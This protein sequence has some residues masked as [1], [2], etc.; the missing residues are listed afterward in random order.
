MDIRTR[1]NKVYVNG[2]HIGEYVFNSKERML[3]LTLNFNIIEEKT[4]REL[5]VDNEY[6]KNTSKI[7]DLIVNQLKNKLKKKIKVND[8]M[9][10]N[11]G[12]VLIIW[13]NIDKS[14]KI[15]YNIS[16]FIKFLM[17]YLKK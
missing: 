9:I 11:D 16:N 14:D 12:E 3:T 13:N 15:S 17:K 2:K 1:N 7:T 4:L 8:I 10:P 5:S 6:I